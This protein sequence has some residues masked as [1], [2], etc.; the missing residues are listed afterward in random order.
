MADNIDAKTLEIL[1]K[2]HPNPKEAVW[3]HKQSGKWLA[4]HKD[5][6]I[7]A[8]NANIIFEDPVVLQFDLE[9][10]IVAFK[11]S[12]LL[13]ER[14]EWTVG[15]ATFYNSQ[16][17][18]YGAMA[19]KRGKDRIILK[20][21]G[22]HGHV[23]SEEEADDFKEAKQKEVKSDKNRPKS[24]KKTQ[25]LIWNIQNAANSDILMNYQATEKAAIDYLQKNY[26]DLFERIEKASKQRLEDFLNG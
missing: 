24:E 9:K 8:A 7:V 13:G 25:D 11:I 18:Y 23:Y 20:L 15:E 26:P 1:Q 14:R 19:E 22:L 21:I 12:G 3:M 17:I 4:K 2:Y 10:K 16:N 6:E 5:L